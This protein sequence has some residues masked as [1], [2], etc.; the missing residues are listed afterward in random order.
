M[1]VGSTINSKQS[2]SDFFDAYYIENIF[3]LIA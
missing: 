2:N 1:Y 3:L